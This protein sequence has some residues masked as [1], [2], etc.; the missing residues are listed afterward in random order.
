[1]SKINRDLPVTADRFKV[2][3]FHSLL[4]WPKGPNSIPRPVRTKRWLPK[5]RNQGL[6]AHLKYV[7]CAKKLPRG[8]GGTDSRLRG[9]GQEEAASRL[10]GDPDWL[11]AK[12]RKPTVVKFLNSLSFASNSISE[13]CNTDVLKITIKYFLHVNVSIWFY[14]ESSH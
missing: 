4:H 5:T 2:L 3:W 7:R 1:M 12:E 11:T 6:M 13:L 9:Q 8:G 14:F 10:R